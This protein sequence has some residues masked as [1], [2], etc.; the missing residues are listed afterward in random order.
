MTI[1]EPMT[2]ATDYLLALVAWVG[3]AR[4]LLAG[5]ERPSAGP[6]GAGLILTGLAAAFGGSLH[7]FAASLS[8]GAKAALWQVI[9]M[10]VG[11]AS[12]LVLAG[13]L[14]ALAPDPPRRGL[15]IAGGV[16][17]GFYVA[18]MAA[19]PSAR[20]AIYDSVVAMLAV[21]ALLVLRRGAPGV[22][23]G[24]AGIL[25]GFGAAALQQARVSFHEH[26]NHNDLFHVVQCV[27]LWL[28]ARAG[29]QLRDL[30]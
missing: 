25:V 6:W 8:P 23:D 26:F 29:R 13:G 16:K 30:G 21:L 5:R 20:Y 3:A 18:W 28:L 22:A 1:R 7:G 2:M 9:Y 15:L 24:I 19:W 27:S 17:L 11:A 10:L 4:L 14:R 12:F